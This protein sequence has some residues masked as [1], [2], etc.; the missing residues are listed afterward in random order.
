MLV[1]FD[2]ANLYRTELKFILPFHLFY[3]VLPYFKYTG[4]VG[5]I[6]I[7]FDFQILGFCLCTLEK[8]TVPCRYVKEFLQSD[9]KS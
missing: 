5:C 4:D 9:W 6:L 1:T 3:Y 8:K 7:W 2:A